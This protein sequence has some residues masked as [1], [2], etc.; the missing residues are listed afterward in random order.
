MCWL[1]SKCSD[2]LRGER[3][4]WKHFRQSL[5][6][7]KKAGGR[8]ITVLMTHNIWSREGNSVYSYAQNQQ[9]EPGDRPTHEPGA[10]ARE[11]TSSLRMQPAPHSWL[12]AQIK[13]S[14]QSYDK[15]LQKSSQSLSVRTVRWSHA[16]ILDICNHSKCNQ[17][18]H[19]SMR[20][21]P[22]LENHISVCIINAPSATMPL[23]PPPLCWAGSEKRRKKTSK[24]L[25]IIADKTVC[26][27]G[28]H[29]G[30]V[31]RE[32]FGHLTKRILS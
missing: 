14:A 24:H 10:A 26:I 18:L 1:E 19:R 27:A 20:S 17:R 23:H 7:W 6:V 3:E 32:M 4:K 12:H 2:I 22:V 15:I 25:W 31:R 28:N 5:N 29:L 21:P 30:G 8:T 11:D 9:D 13:R 16:A